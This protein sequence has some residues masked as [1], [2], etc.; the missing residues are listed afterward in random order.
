MSRLIETRFPQKNKNCRI[1]SLNELDRI[2]DANIEFGYLGF[3]EKF[4]YISSI[5]I[6]KGMS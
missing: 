4:G 6:R 3:S 1:I 5:E 2:R